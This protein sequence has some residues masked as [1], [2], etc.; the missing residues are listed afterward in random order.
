MNANISPTSYHWS[1]K[2]IH[3][4]SALAI[5]GLFASGLWMVG[6][7]YYSDWYQ[8][9]PDW[10]RSVGILL[11]L[12]TS[13]RL[14]LYFIPQPAALSTH[15]RYERVLAKL[16]K[17]ILLLLLVVMFISGYLIT[18]ATGD[19]IH[20]FN[21]FSLPSVVQ[22]RNLEDYAGEVHEWVA[23]SI[24]VLASLHALAALK[25]HFYDKDATLRR[26]TYSK[27]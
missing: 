5:V 25:H 18:T 24:I 8:V 26:M 13:L 6:L 17:S 10:H 22:V 4:L 3:W 11:A 16:T 20:I 12:C 23:W 9:T 7:D 1:T 14:V 19:P 15:Q 2:I 27:H 21:W